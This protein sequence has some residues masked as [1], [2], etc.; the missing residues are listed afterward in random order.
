MPRVRLA[1]AAILYS[2]SEGAE[3]KATQPPRRHKVARPE[4]LGVRA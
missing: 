2:S 1:A 4:C 3:F